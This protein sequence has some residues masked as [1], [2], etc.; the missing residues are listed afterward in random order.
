[1]KDVLARAAA[2]GLLDG[3]ELGKS[4][5]REKKKKKSKLSLPKAPTNDNNSLQMKITEFLNRETNVNANRSEILTTKTSLP[6]KNATTAASSLRVRKPSKPATNPLVPTFMRN[7]AHPRPHERHTN[8]LRP[9]GEDRVIALKPIEIVLPPVMLP[10]SSA[11]GI[12]SQIPTQHFYYH[13]VAPK[14]GYFPSPAITR[15]GEKPKENSP[16][17]LLRHPRPW[18]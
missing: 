1:M 2:K 13:W 6:Q 12:K 10:F 9:R 18:L 14:T 4:S 7:P 3:I 17:S 15:R 5:K 11:Q 16:S 8:F